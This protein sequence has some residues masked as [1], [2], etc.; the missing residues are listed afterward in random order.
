MIY[1]KRVEAGDF[2][3]YAPKVS[4]YFFDVYPSRPRHPL[5][6]NNKFWNPVPLEDI[7]EYFP[8]LIEGTLH[9]GKIKEVSILCLYHNSTSLH[10]DH[11]A[12]L[13]NGVVARLNIP[14]LNTKGS[15][16][17]F[18]KISESYPYKTDAGGSKWWDI[19]LGHTLDPVSVVDI[20]EPTIIRTN[21]PHMVH[22]KSNK[23]PRIT[24]TMSFEEDVV[25]Y[26]Y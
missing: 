23:L 4:S 14:I 25:K 13:N 15:H 10:T 2:R 18:Y 20:T 12:G 3:S 7:R 21:E 1:W 26:L 17:A 9:L 5:L 6:K 19:N 11:T 22:C 8:E 24:L 16:T